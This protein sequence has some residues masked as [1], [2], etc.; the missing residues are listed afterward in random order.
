MEMSSI[1]K[2]VS[3]SEIF[4]NGEGD[5]WFHHNQDKIEARDGATKELTF[6]FDTLNDF[7]GEVNKILEIGCGSGTKLRKLS[8]Y[9]NASGSGIDPSKIAIEEAQ[10]TVGR[11]NP[12]LD[13]QVGIAS[14]LPFERDS[15]DIVF[16][17]FCLYLIPPAEIFQAVKEAD[18]VLKNGG[19]LIILDFDYGGLKINQYVHTS[20]V[21]TYKNSYA[22]LF[23]SSN[24][25]SLISKWSFNHETSYF[26]KV[27]DERISVEILFKEQT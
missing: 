1:K 21:L 8:D 12:P 11:H 4:L 5:A 27:R 10:H 22:Q 9:F 2:P 25:Y 13:F 16:F 26:T 24:Y 6:I 23:T 17:G 3:Q 15:F 19:F 18:R 20:E 14:E 7:S